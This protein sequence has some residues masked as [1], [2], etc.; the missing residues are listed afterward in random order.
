MDYHYL[1][2]FSTLW[3]RRTATLWPLCHSMTVLH[4]TIPL[5]ASAGALP[6]FAAITVVAL[7]AERA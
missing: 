1:A 3:Q 6:W 4:T 7:E 2:G 5:G